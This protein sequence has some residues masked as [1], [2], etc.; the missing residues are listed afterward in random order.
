MTQTT[1]RYARQS[2]LETTSISVELQSKESFEL[3]FSQQRLTNGSLTIVL[4]HSFF[5]WKQ[6]QFCFPAIKNP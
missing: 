5:P 6:L 2:Q 3:V 4:Q 1:M